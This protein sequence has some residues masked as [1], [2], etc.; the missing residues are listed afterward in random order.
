MFALGNRRV[1]MPALIRLTSWGTAAALALTLAVVTS[2]SATGSRRAG[3]AVAALTGREEPPR[4][5]AIAQLVP[6]PSD[7]EGETRRLNEAIRLLAAD[8]DRLLTRV[9]SLERNL[10]DMTGSVSRAAGASKPMPADPEPPALPPVSSLQPA[11]PKTAAPPLLMPTPVPTAEATVPESFLTTM[12]ASL[13]GRT[14][15]WPSAHAAV[16]AAPPGAPATTP[17]PGRV[18]A[19]A[20]AGAATGPADTTRTG[21]IG[22]KTEFGVDIGSAG[23]LDTLQ[24]IWTETKARHGALVNGL[25][26][27]VVVREGK[28]GGTELRLVI[29][30]FSNASAAAK[31]CAQLG[32]ADILCSAGKFDGQRLALH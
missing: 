29:G 10:D 20:P 26:P 13:P 4:Q 17:V 16:A 12:T 1:D 23:D 18:A 27:V 11:P 2:L 9:G 21:S 15:G 30:P 14:R 24:A 19:T 6:R 25:R 8:R 5:V 3:V 32:A 28:A 7:L 22:T 31:L